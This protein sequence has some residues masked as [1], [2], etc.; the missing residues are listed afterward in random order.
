MVGEIRDSET[1]ELA[2]RAALTGHL[3][4]STLHTN[5]AASAIVRLTDMGIEP[6]LVASAVNCIVAQRLVRRTCPKC[7]GKGGNCLNCGGSGFHGRLGLYEI[8]RLG[9]PLREMIHARKSVSELKQKAIELGMKT[10]ADDGREKIALGL[11]TEAEVA[12]EVV[13]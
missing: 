13:A 4:F 6:F 12:S 11:T 10:L 2:I 7:G 8:L 1:A 3:V 5:D 9:E